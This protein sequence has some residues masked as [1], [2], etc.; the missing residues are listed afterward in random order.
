MYQD[1]GYLPGNRDDSKY[2][3][4]SVNVTESIDLAKWITEYMQMPKFTIIR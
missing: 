2:E 1:L 4:G 3:F